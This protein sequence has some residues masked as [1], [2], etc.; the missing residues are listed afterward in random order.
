MK[1]EIKKGSVV[2]SF[3]DKLVTNKDKKK[4]KKS[5]LL[6]ITSVNKKTKNLTAI[7]IYTHKND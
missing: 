2:S 3:D 1:K 4:S 7:K 5:R 6:A